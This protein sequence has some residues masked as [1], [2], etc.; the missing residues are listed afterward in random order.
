M[1]EAWP[2]PMELFLIR[3]LFLMTLL[4]L[5]LYGQNDLL[6]FQRIG[7]REGLS[8]NWVF[9]IQEDYLG[10]M[11]FGTQDG[12]NKYDGKTIKIFRPEPGNHKKLARSW[13]QDIMESGDRKLWIVSD[14][15]QV[16][17]FDRESETF[18]TLDPATT[19]L[20]EFAN[21]GWL[22]THRDV[23]GDVWLGQPNRTVVIHYRCEDKTF[24]AI[25]LTKQFP[26]I[27]G[28]S[29]IRRD[30]RDHVWFA[31]NQNG[32]L[33][34]DLNTQEQEHFVTSDTE[35]ISSA[36][37]PVRPTFKI[38]GKG[39]LLTKEKVWHGLVGGK[40]YVLDRKTRNF[41]KVVSNTAMGNLRLLVQQGQTVWAYFQGG[42][43]LKIDSQTL[44]MKQYKHDPKDPQS[45]APPSI[46]DAAVDKNGVLWLASITH[47]LMQYDAEKD[48]FIHQRHDPS[49]PSSL[50]GDDITSMYMDSNENI[51]LGMLNDGV[52]VLSPERQKFK[53]Y[54]TLMTWKVNEAE[55]GV[56]VS[57]ESQGLIHFDDDYQTV[58][59]RYHA[60]AK[61][62]RFRI[63]G[64]RIQAASFIPGSGLWFASGNTNTGQ[65]ALYWANLKGELKQGPP[66]F[67][68]QNI[69][70]SRFF[71]DH[72]V[73]PLASNLALFGKTN[74]QAKSFGSW[75]NL[76]GINYVDF[77]EDERYMYAI[78]YDG[79]R[80]LDPINKESK[81][82]FDSN[83]LG[84]NTSNAAVLCIYRSHDGIIW[85]GTLGGGINR[86]DP[87]T[88]E[89]SFI[90]TADG[91]PNNVV[92]AILE[93]DSNALW[94]SSNSGLTRYEPQT[95][96]VRNF[97]VSHGLQSNE[98]NQG[99]ALRR[100]NGEFLFGGVNGFNVFVPKDVMK[101]ARKP[102]LIAH[103]SKN[104]Y[105]MLQLEIANP[106][107]VV[108]QPN[109]ELL[110]IGYV[111]IDF[112]S[113]DHRYAYQ[114]SGIHTDWVP[115]NEGRGA[116]FT[117]LPPGDYQFKVKAATSGENWTQPLEI[118]VEVLPNFY[119]TALFAALLWL[120]GLIVVITIIFG[121]WRHHLAQ[122]AH[123]ELMRK[124]DELEYAR[125][126]QLAML[127]HKDFH[128]PGLDLVGHMVTAT[129][130]GGDY[131]DFIMLDDRRLLIAYGDATGHGV[132]AGLVVGMTKMACTVVSPKRG[133]L[134]SIMSDLN[135][136]LKRTLTVRHMGMALGLV[137]VDLETKEIEMCL[138]GM[139][140]P[141]HYRAASQSLNPVTLKA[142]PL[143]YLSKIDAPTIQMKLEPG[144]QLVM[145]TDGFAERF[146]DDHV[147][148]GDKNL[149]TSLERIC[150]QA[151]SPA[152]AVSRLI[153][154]CDHH[155]NG[156]PNDDDMTVVL[157]KVK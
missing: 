79:M 21:N 50:P 68:V 11:W 48:Y 119:E 1:G 71:P 104:S 94:L 114:M 7:M 15:G 113:E 41:Q 63:L 44:E 120:G 65:S 93:D 82:Y 102:R 129:E 9:D 144:D 74:F 25:D 67:Q 39:L 139:P 116:A 20:P 31:T 26:Q 84:S 18:T 110:E 101:K 123:K 83:S 90:T 62:P 47:G 135:T 13:V 16:Q 51:W 22:L 152:D 157:M 97:N 153:T 91:I 130:V 115:D 27:T 151:T 19:G 61:D 28:V 46:A 143:G 81:S 148:W 69:K 78:T 49:R 100:S 36:R 3:F 70:V 137:L 134:A 150:M 136:G 125:E 30:A 66:M 64:N 95:G 128:A 76:G 52:S 42:I 111:A 59:A 105:T 88:D 37:T 118:E 132:A 145:L 57:T 89:V 8:Q 107:Q 54:S 55:R 127:P 32:L 149:R 131:Y 2:L 58:L 56:L 98:F 156:R 142:P 38:L 60:E 45:L 77:V 121:I 73:V 103:A 85:N 133:D 10:F 112:K 146:N 43:L 5:P 72:I 126:M 99:A 12:L 109:D 34:Q 6:R 75:A 17:W 141:Y 33:R 147:M 96:K 23:F 92:Y 106:T 4:I 138:A 154:A 140:T 80:R 86:L 29:G 35:G 117:S 53:H 108:L 24:K 14:V 155:A 122:M 124:T 87:K 40:L